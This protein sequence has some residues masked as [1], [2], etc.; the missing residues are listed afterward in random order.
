MVAIDMS[1][2]CSVIVVREHAVLL[3][4][5]TSDGLDD[6]VLPGGTP[7]T[8]E[9]MASCARRELLEETGLTADPARVAFILEAVAP[10]S[11]RHALDI[12]FLAAE[13]VLGMI[14]GPREPGLE[15]QFVVL[16][17]LAELGLRPPLASYLDS[18]LDAGVQE[19][20]PYFGIPWRPAGQ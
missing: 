7:R 14:R 13:P 12:V 2:R 18:L 15:P 5:R 17:Q 20:A 9:S 4:H 11:G 19:C 1:I 3:V 8:G 6:W 16:G 10:G